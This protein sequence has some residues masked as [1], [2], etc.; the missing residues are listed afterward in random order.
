MPKMSLNFF[1]LFLR[2]YTVL[3]H[4]YFFRN[5]RII[6]YFCTFVATAL[7][8]RPRK[9]STCAFR[10]S[11]QRGYDARGSARPCR[12][13]NNNAVQTAIQGSAQ[14]VKERFQND[15]RYVRGKDHI[16]NELYLHTQVYVLRIEY[17]SRVM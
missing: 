6:D 12:R 15:F 5:T 1:S 2:T 7:F 9:P 17:R 14:T 8:Q 10:S 11:H 4:R 16:L 13:R 3:L